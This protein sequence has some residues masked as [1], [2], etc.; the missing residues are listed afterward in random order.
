MSVEPQQ[1]TAAELR[2][3]LA[4]AK[5]IAVVGLS[6]R[7]ERPSYTVAAYLQRQ[8]YRIIPVNPNLTEALGEKAYPNLRDIPE[9]VD[10]VDVFRRSEHVP[11]AVEDAIAIGAKVLW[12]QIGVI[13][14][15]A[16]ARAEAA[17]LT[18]VRD[19]CIAVSHRLL[20]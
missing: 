4:T 6:H 8:G 13:H 9:R 2:Q 16:A 5:T 18:V 20:F 14:E 3:I 19:N 17:G 15:E 1:K 11:A 7:S 12:L 10:I